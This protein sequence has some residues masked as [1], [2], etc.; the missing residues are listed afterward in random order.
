MDFEMKKMAKISLLSGVVMSNSAAMPLGA[1]DPEDADT[2]A[3]VQAAIEEALEAQREEHSAEVER[4]NTKNKDLLKKLAKAREGTDNAGEV[5]RLERELD[6]TKHSLGEA[7]SKLRIAER[8]LKKITSERD[9]AVSER[10]T[11]RSNFRNELIENNLTAAL[12]EHQVAPHFMEAAKALLK[13]KVSVEVDGDE[14]KL[15]ADGK[16]IGDFV[17]EWAAS[18]AGKH[19]V[20]APANGG[21]G[22]NGANGGGSPGGLKP[23]AE[24]TE[25]ERVEMARTRPDEWRQVQQTAGI[26]GENANIIQ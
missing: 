15:L 11:E 22:A 14:R 24:Y 21:G 3:A 26:T 20:V 1:Y 25:A 23:L 8:D 19:Y 2:K 4:L 17:K 9:T 10:D 18:D 16:P 6:E 7:Q 12:V 13:G 5:E